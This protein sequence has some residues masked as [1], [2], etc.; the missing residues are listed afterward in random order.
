MVQTFSRGG[1][2]FISDGGSRG[3][4]IGGLSSKGA[5]LGNSSKCISRQ[6]VSP[7]PLRAWHHSEK[8]SFGAVL[9]APSKSE[10]HRK[11]AKDAKGDSHASNS[12]SVIG[13]ECSRRVPT[14]AGHRSVGVGL[15]FVKSS[16]VLQRLVQ[17]R[18]LAIDLAT[19]RRSIPPLVERSTS[20]D[21]AGRRSPVVTDVAGDY[22]SKKSGKHHR[23]LQCTT[24][25]EIF[26]VLVLVLSIAVLVLVLE[27][28][29]YIYPVYWSAISSESPR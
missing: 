23:R 22:D 13:F 6:F 24:L 8:P 11:G 7:N 2:R 21:R 10:P 5:Y 18:D 12:K 17:K 26:L 14:S 29:E 4:A 3:S 19:P 9:V 1:L 15:A 25:F 16:L 28:T 20:T 27:V